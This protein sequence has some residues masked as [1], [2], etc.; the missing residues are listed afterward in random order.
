[1][2]RFGSRAA[3][4]ILYAGI[5]AL[6]TLVWWRGMVPFTFLGP[7]AGNIASFAAAWSHPG[8][9]HG[10]MVLANTENFRFYAILHIP[11]LMGLASLLGDFGTAFVVLLWPVMWLQAEGYWR[12]GRLLFGQGGGA[13]ALGLLSFGTVPLTIDY[14]GTYVDAEPRFLFQAILPFLL[15]GL[16]GAADSPKGWFRLFGLH[17]LSMY[18]HP[19]STPSVALA[20]WL[21]LALRGPGGAPAAVWVWRLV[22]AGVVFVAVIV[23][24]GINYLTGH[25]H[26]ATADYAE[27]IARQH[28]L[29]GTIFMD[30]LVYAQT[31][32]SQWRA[33]WFVPAWGVLG[34]M[35][36]WVLAPHQRRRLVLLTAWMVLVV[37][38][39]LGVTLL[40]QAIGRHFQLLPVEI[41][42]IRNMRYGVPILMVFGLWGAVEAAGRMPRR[43]GGLLIGAVACVWLVVNKPGGLPVRAVADCLASGRLSCPSGEWLDRRAMLAALRDK[44]ARGTPVLPFV[45]RYEGL[46]AVLA[47]RYGA[48]LPVAFCFKDGGTALGYANHGVLDRWLELSERLNEAHRSMDWRSLVATADEL[49]AGI[50]VTDLEPPP[51]SGW[52]VIHAG[53]RYR[54]LARSAT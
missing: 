32:L 40:E 41:D 52:A 9:W 2:A 47:V 20:S 30:G 43:R 27:A 45:D 10:D 35:A 5:S 51:L 21:T 54:V 18:V 38:T 53:G 37:A 42:S 26:G 33:R 23:P 6:L 12:L 11:L 16:L 28:R 22:A 50:I 39:S 36:V 4:S 13:L 3:I 1:M 49:G 7:D 14:Y 44:V 29:F 15:I 25:Q 17:G 34:A 31:M 46:D 24:F 19:V 8:Q 48:L